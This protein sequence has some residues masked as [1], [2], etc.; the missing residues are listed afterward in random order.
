MGTVVKTSHYRNPHV[1][2]DGVAYKRRGPIYRTAVI[3][4]F[5]LRLQL[6]MWM[7]VSFEVGVGQMLETW[8]DHGKRP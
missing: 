5:G 4:E 7:E 8:A 3:S 2:E 1:K 6:E